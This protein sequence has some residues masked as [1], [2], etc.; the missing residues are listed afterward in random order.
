MWQVAPTY[1]DYERARESFT[2]D[3]PAAF[4][5]GVD[6]VRKH[7]PDATG[8]VV[9][10]EDAA[11][12]GPVESYSFGGLDT[13]SD[14]L[15]AG[16]RARGVERGDRVGV[17]LPQVAATPLS[18]LACWKAGAVSV[19]L[20]T[21]FGRDALEHRLGDAD[22]VA[23]VAAGDVLD[24][25]RSATLPALESLF[26]VDAAPGTAAGVATALDARHEPLD[27]VAA[28]G[29]AAAFT[30]HDA[31]PATRTAIMYT[32]GSTGPPKG[33]LHS[34]ALWLGR[35][36][37]AQQFFEGYRV[38]PD[39]PADD[40]TVW[41]PA[42]W[43]WG[44]ALG[45]TLLGAWHHG[46]RVVGAPRE[47]FDPEWAFG[48]MERFDVTHA[49][50][51]PTAIRMLMT[52]DRPAERWDLSLSAIGSA[53]EPLTPEILDWADDA[54]PHV[55][56]NEFY[57][58]TELN[59]VVGNNRR[60]FDAEPGSMGKPFPGY[61]L[62]LLDPETRE[63]VDRG[64]VG[65]I[66][67]RPGD[68]RVFFDEY[69]NRP[70]A[71]AAK[72]VELDGRTWFLTDDLATRGE[73]GYVRFRSRT[74][75]VILASGYRV[76]PL[77]VERVLLDHP[78]VEQAGVVGAPDETRGEVIQAHVQPV[79]EL[80]PA[81]HDRVRAELRTAC[82]DRLAEYEY[83]REIRFVDELPTTSTGKIRRADLRDGS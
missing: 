55:S 32:S 39:A 34:H 76:G 40:V 50:L 49:F 4:N 30:A 9:A 2:W 44:A 11:G 67:L 79:A 43:A 63:P 42:D 6:M 56:V 7:D 22:A 13:R 66:A 28:A 65:E 21:L 14:A 75:D 33:V 71:T 83:P 57:G 78:D 12:D 36:A 1:D 10:P 48:L 73:D 54:L 31:T 64:E 69:W 72:T 82:R 35:A 62:A 46:H 29:D 8:L 80:D 77:E 70:E 47:S 15:A 53:G 74:D 27:D 60:W 3:L 81:D 24:D 23:L 25:L 68:R 45:G 19:P 58:Q 20:T 26:T 52:V 5:P 37:A 38:R 51:P 61:E 18:H 17:C 16:L 59:L 41:T